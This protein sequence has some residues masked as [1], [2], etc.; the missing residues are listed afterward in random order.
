MADFVWKLSVAGIFLA[1]EVPIGVIAY[2]ANHS[3]RSLSVPAVL[4]LLGVIVPS[5]VWAALLLFL[6]LLAM[7]LVAIGSRA[8]QTRLA[9]QREMSISGPS[10]WLGQSRR[11]SLALIGSGAGLMLVATALDLG[12]HAGT[13]A[14]TALFA[15]G[16]IMLG[17]GLFRR[18]TVLVVYLG[19]RR[20]R[21]LEVLQVT[22]GFV[23]YGFIATGEFS[24]DSEQRLAFRLLSLVPFALQFLFVWVPLTKA[25][26]R[27]VLPETPFA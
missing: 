10:P 1:L 14:G 20:A 6:S 22:A 5:P 2:R 9:E 12:R 25:Q 4:L 13:L 19:S 16:S 23:A 21:W 24:R 15:W 3:L 26:E 18:H 17:I 8:R 11:S 7:F 27:P